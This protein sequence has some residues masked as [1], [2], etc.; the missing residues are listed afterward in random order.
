MF[1]ESSGGLFRVTQA[2]DSLPTSPHVAWDEKNPQCIQA[3]SSKGH[4]G[5]MPGYPEVSHLEPGIAA[6][7]YML[8]GHAPGLGFCPPPGFTDLSTLGETVGSSLSS[9]LPH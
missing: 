7:L 6:L 9:Q 5:P 8:Q 4:I 2:S 3:S 1:S